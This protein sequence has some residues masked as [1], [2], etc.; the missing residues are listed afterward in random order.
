MYRSFEAAPPL[1]LVQARDSA[2][3][4]VYHGNDFLRRKDGTAVKLWV[5]RQAFDV[6]DEHVL[7]K[8]GKSVCAYILA[9][10]DFDPP[11]EKAD[12]G[13]CFSSGIWR[14]RADWG[15]PG[16]QAGSS[17]RGWVAA[18]NRP[19]NQTT[20]GSSPLSIFL[21]V[22]KS[23]GTSLAEAL[24]P[25]YP[26]C[27]AKWEC[28]SGPIGPSIESFLRPQP[29]EVAGGRQPAGACNL[30]GCRGHM[31]MTTIEGQL[32][33]QNTSLHDAILLTMLRSPVDRV[34]SEHQYALR[35]HPK[36][37]NTLQFLQTT[38]G[39]HKV[40]YKLLESNMS[41][42][43]YVSFPFGAGNFGAINNRQVSLL[44][45]RQHRHEAQ[46]CDP[47]NMDYPR[48]RWPKSPRVSIKWP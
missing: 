17:F 42:A 9:H 8:A 24:R 1:T 43:D 21:H 25:V 22:P 5:P 32:A 20:V 39:R 34:I 44:A 27:G 3:M 26:S 45:G 35:Q 15:A 37:A 19:V 7:R 33:H 13:T 28:Q 4:L 14:L 10:G 48:K 11:L 6:Y 41:L 36:D 2:G 23:A 18:V 30:W 47:H 12:A 46:V 38:D 31:D 16:R 40:L 29:E